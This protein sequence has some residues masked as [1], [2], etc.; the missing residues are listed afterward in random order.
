[1]FE[2]CHII[3]ELQAGKEIIESEGFEN[4]SFKVHYDKLQEKLDAGIQRVY[5]LTQ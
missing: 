3:E 1:M 4:D 2:L 5:E